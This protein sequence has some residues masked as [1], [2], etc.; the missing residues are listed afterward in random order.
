MPYFF[1]AAA[2]AMFFVGAAIGTALARAYAPARAFFPFVW[3]IWFWGSLGFLVANALFLLGFWFV[4]LPVMDANSLPSW[5]HY[6]LS[7]L[8]GVTVLLGPFIVSSVGVGGGA[9]L[10]CVFAWRSGK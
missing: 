6:I 5:L 10:G 8:G 7:I 4:L 1:V 9:L 2:F 3:R